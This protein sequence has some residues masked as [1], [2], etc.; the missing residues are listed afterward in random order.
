MC[1]A[2]KEFTG[3]RTSEEIIDQID[4]VVRRRFPTARLT[5]QSSRFSLPGW[6]N[7]RLIRLYWM[8]WE[9]FP[10]FIKHLV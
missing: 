5:Y 4:Y 8:F 2:G 6:V 9:N 1:D 3:N 7:R 10:Q